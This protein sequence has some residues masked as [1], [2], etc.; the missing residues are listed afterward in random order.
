MPDDPRVIVE[1]GYDAI[2]GPYADAAREGRGPATYFS[3]FLGRVLEFIPEDGLVLD[4]GCGAGL[5]AAE[6]TTRARVVGVDISSAQLELARRN[7]PDASLVRADVG[8]VAFEPRS[9]DAVVAFWSLIHVPR[10]LHGSLIA[11][12]HA[13]L[14]PGGVFA[15]TLGSGDN[16]AEHVQ[17]FYGAPMYWSHFDAE[18]NR[19][20]LREAGFDVLQADEIEDEGETPLW[21]VARA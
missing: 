17:D 12:I 1:S 2:A 18:N 6:I 21:V 10:E 15:G 14:K 20:L 5:I 11:R 8:E 19:R 4:I 13:W 7:A 3:N 9:F 16:P